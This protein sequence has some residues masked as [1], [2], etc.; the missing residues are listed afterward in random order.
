MWC[1]LAGWVSRPRKTHDA[2]MFCYKQS[3][4]WADCDHGDGVNDPTKERNDDSG[5]KKTTA[6]MMKAALV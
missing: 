4:W 5:D 6:T 2:M 1:D 3:E